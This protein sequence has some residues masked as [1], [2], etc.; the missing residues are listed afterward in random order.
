SGTFTQSGGTNSLGGSSGELYLGYNTGSGGTYNL[1]GSGVL[2]VSGTESVGYS[3]TGTFNQA[4][5][6]STVGFL[7]IGALGLYQIGGGT[8]QITGGGLASQGTLA[9]TGSTGVLAVTGSAIVDFSTG[10]LQN[11]AS[12]SLSIGPDSLLLVPAGF[13]PATAFLSYQNQGLLHNVGAPLT[14]AA[15][16]GFSGNGSIADFVNCQGTIS[17]GGGW[18]NLNGGLT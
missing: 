5:G 9:A 2:S 3:G 18:I 7:S 6:S 1:S 4:G 11:A 14:I 10:T 16:Q 13:N 8:L 12:L 17:A 15:G